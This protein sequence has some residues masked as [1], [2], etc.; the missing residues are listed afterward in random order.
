MKN[1]KFEYN[2]RKMKETHRNNGMRLD[3]HRGI[4][5]YHLYPEP[6]RDKAWWD[7]FS[8]IRNNYKVVVW[9][10]HPRMIYHDKVTSAV[11]EEALKI[12]PE[13]DSFDKW[14]DKAN[15]NYKKVGKSRKKIVTYTCPESTKEQQE[16]YARVKWEEEIAL[17]TSAFS[18]KPSIKI[19]CLDWCRGVSLCA[20][21]EAVSE[22]GL[23]QLKTLVTRLLNG[24]TTLEKEFPN[25]LYT[26]N[27]WIR[28]NPEPI[29]ALPLST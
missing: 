7:D 16:W 11:F 6:L 12:K 8:F 26:S 25:Y 23:R 4:H 18:V 28:E 19:E 10:T 20:P 2:R 29:L 5:A 1:K 17:T 22:D 24:E 21:V 27:D 13:R 3:T 15:A 9:F 14:F